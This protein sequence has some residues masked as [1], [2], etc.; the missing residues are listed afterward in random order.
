MYIVGMLRPGFEHPM[1][2]MQRKYSYQLCHCR[3]SGELKVGSVW[4]MSKGKAQVN[5]RK[6]R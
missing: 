1:F 6:R 2:R 5:E 3:G 4:T